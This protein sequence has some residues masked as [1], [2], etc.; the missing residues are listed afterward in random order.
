MEVIQGILTGIFRRSDSGY[1]I[2]GIDPN[3][4]KNLLIIVLKIM[5][6]HTEILH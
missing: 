5:Y 2:A 1:H 6:K 4:T 3:G